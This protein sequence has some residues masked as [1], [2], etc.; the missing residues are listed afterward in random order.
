MPGGHHPIHLDDRLDDGR[1][2]V[3]HKLGDE[4]LST[5]WLCQDTRH[6]TTRYI[7]V[8]V[9]KASAS[10]P[11]CHEV[12]M[13]RRLKQL[14]IDAEREH[15]CLSLER[16]HV[17]G[18]NETHLCIVCPVLDP[19]LDSFIAIYEVEQGLLEC[20][21]CTTKLDQIRLKSRPPSEV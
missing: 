2:R 11:D 14:A 6:D 20:A 8:K 19:N 1:Y 3:I 7:A 16:F 5:V 10:G 15:I 13:M 9:L 17:L 21:G 12:V 4:G 18:T